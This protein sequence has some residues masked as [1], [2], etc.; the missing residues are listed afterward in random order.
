MPRIEQLQQMLTREPN[1]VFLNF[2][3]AKEYANQNA[4]E[5]LAWFDRVIELDRTYVAAYFQK[6]N[7]L[8][9]MDRRDEAREVFGQGLAAAEEINDTHAAAELRDALAMLK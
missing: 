7:L 9:A 2:A 6:A 1:D 3:M 4:P 5:A 8:V